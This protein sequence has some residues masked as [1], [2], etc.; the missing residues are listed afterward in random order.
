MRVFLAG[1]TG[2]IGSKIS[3]QLVKRGHQVVG[4][5]RSAAKTEALRAAGVEPVVLDLLD[6]EAVRSAVLAARPEAILHEG[7][8]LAGL[9]KLKHFDRAFAETNRLRTAGTDALLAAAREAGVARFVAQSYTGWPY[10]RQGGALKTE[11]DP[12]DTEPAASMRESLAA[13]VHLERAV[14]KAGGI[15]LRYGSFYGSPRDPQVDLVRKRLLP[16]LGDGG[17]IWSF[18]H[19]DDAAS[20]TV[21]AL[22]R[23]SAG[24]Y[25]IS[26]DEPAPVREW[27]PFLAS[28]IGAKPPL[29]IPR[30]LGRMV[31]GDAVVLMMTEAPGASN[32]K[33]KRELGWTLRYPTW[34]QGF[35]AT[36][37]RPT[38]EPA[39]R[40]M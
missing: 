15:S 20:A 10:A 16:I 23:G 14:V 13:I 28:V 29:H 21:L 32:Q 30:W 27:L 33:A 31:A 39:A 24:S 36:Y 35:P 18:V 37:R 1:A 11:D 8:A 7:T 34:R 4:T 38:V 5:T 9:E 40:A 25:N 3:R 6:A 2:A 26:D 22:E 17:G 19:L 12:L